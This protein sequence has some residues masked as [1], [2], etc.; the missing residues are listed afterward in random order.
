MI[1][2]PT[3]QDYKDVV[4]T[5]EDVSKK[6][7]EL[8]ELMKSTSSALGKMQEELEEMPSGY[9]NAQDIKNLKGR[10]EKLEQRDYSRTSAMDED[11][12]RVF[13]RV[14][15]L[16]ELLQSGKNVTV[17][18]RLNDMEISIQ[19]TAAMRQEHNKAHAESMGH[20]Q[21][22]LN[23]QLKEMK[24]CC[25]NTVASGKELEKR[26]DFIQNNGLGRTDIREIVRD[27][28]KSL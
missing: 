24:E 3:Y 5:L 2:V 7:N 11:V 28:L 9:R 16:E 25:K 17:H 14:L 18:S 15:H 12:K 19:N 22:D 6:H 27:I 1:E 4:N 26:I 20:I 8:V 21:D 10:I 13:E 23:H